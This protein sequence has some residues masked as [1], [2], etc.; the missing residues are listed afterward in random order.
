MATAAS[1]FLRRAVVMGNIYVHTRM[2]AHPNKLDRASLPARED[3]V[4]GS[5]PPAVWPRHGW[6]IYVAC[7]AKTEGSDLIPGRELTD[8]SIIR[9]VISSLSF[10]LRFF[11]ALD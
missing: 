3:S 9:L 8:R 10:G 7:G 6:S 5:S 2:S 11:D 4:R 1:A